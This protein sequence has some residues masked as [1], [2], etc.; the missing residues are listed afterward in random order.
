[1]L[2]ERKTHE[3]F[4]RTMKVEV[5]VV[6]CR[7]REALATFDQLNKFFT[8]SQRPVAVSQYWRTQFMSFFQ[9]KQ[10]KMQR[11]FKPCVP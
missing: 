3:S 4:M 6:S 11:D 5:A 7:R 8:I 2:E 9:M 10:F 1:M